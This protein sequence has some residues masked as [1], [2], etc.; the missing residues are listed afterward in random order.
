MI[1]LKKILNEEL[2]S[3]MSDPDFQISKRDAS[4]PVKDLEFTTYKKRL[5]EDISKDLLFELDYFIKYYA[6]TGPNTSRELL[7]IKSRLEK[8]KQKVP[9]FQKI[10]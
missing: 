8:L 7:Q 5:I 6:K 3:S 4:H 9:N 10:K 2:G 1:K